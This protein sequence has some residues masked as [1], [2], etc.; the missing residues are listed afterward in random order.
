[1]S[2]KSFRPNFRYR[3]GFNYYI[4]NKF[5]NHLKDDM[6]NLREDFIDF[7]ISLKEDVDFLYKNKIIYIVPA[8]NKHRRK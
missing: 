6:E 7:A 1:M 5:W 3:G 4:W 8:L 2:W